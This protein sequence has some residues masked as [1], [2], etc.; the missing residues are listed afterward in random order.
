MIKLIYI[1]IENDK[2]YEFFATSISIAES[3]ANRL[4]ATGLYYGF[5]YE[6]C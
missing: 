4:Q 5:T 1:S 3:V 6:Q 2:V